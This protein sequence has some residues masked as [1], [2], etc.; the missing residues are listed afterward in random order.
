MIA[1]IPVDT[2]LIQRYDID[3]DQG[4]LYIKTAWCRELAIQCFRNVGG[5]FPIGSSVNVY[6]IRK[7]PGSDYQPRTRKIAPTVDVE[8]QINWLL[9]IFDIM[10]TNII[11]NSHVGFCPHHQN[12]KGPHKLEIC[13]NNEMNTEV[14]NQY[15]YIYGTVR[16]IPVHWLLLPPVMSFL[17]LL[18]RIWATLEAYP[19]HW[20]VLSDTKICRRPRGKGGFLWVALA[21]RLLLPSQICDMDNHHFWVFLNILTDASSDHIIRQVARKKLLPSECYNKSGLNEWSTSIL[22]LLRNE[23]GVQQSHILEVNE[24]LS[25]R[26]PLAYISLPKFSAV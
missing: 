19:R 15:G 11:S 6:G 13:L 4:L 9:N 2:E 20:Q 14:I 23:P 16:N 26:G 22:N 3:Y 18:P 17:L 21:K 1:V 8:K 5:R 25:K 24:M 10:V 12:I 7:H